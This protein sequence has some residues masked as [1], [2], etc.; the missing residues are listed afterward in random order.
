M[1]EQTC[2][3]PP[4]GQ[5]RVET[6][7]LHPEQEV[8]DYREAMALAK[9]EAEKQLGEFMDVLVRPGPGLRIA[10]QYDGM[11]RQ[12]REERLYPLCGEPRGDPQG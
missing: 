2:P 5:P 9:E 7:S 3:L 4:P 10:A 1:S 8:A 12:L 6:V 11:R